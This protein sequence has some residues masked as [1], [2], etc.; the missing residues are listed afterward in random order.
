MKIS[1]KMQDALNGQV[2]AELYSAYLYLSMSAYFESQNLGGLAHWL[3][4]QAREETGHAMKIYDYVAE[5]GGTVKLA[6]IKAPPARWDS[7]LNAF[8]DAYAHE[9]K[10]T[11]MINDLLK[12]A[13]AEN[14]P[15]TA[16]RLQWFVTEQVEEEA[17]TDDVV[18][19]LR[20]IGASKNGLF[21]LDAH[22]GKRE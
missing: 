9:T 17:T 7:P 1:T 6:E 15:A 4:V 16:A 22:L 21:M 10:V 18:Q 14:D 8:E 3:R 20:M 12:I 19:K 5:R 11:V 2:N 13:H